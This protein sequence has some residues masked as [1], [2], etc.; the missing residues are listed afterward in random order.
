MNT[1]DKTPD[2]TTPANTVT[3][4]NRTETPETDAAIAAIREFRFDNDDFSRTSSDRVT[5]YVPIP[6][7]EL[8]PLKTDKWPHNKEER[9]NPLTIRKAQKLLAA[10]YAI[11]PCELDEAG[12]YGYAWIIETEKQWVNRKGTAPIIPPGKPRLVKLSQGAQPRMEYEEA[13][14]EYRVYNHLAQEGKAKLNAWFGADMF[15]DLF[16]DGV[17]PVETTPLQMIEHLRVTYATGA[18]DRQ[19][20]ERVEK[21]FDCIY[22]PKKPVETYFQRVR[23]AMTDAL[24]LEQPYTEQQAKNKTLG[25][26]ERCYGE[27]FTKAEA[28]WLEETNNDWTAFTTFWKKQILTWS[29]LKQ[30]AYANEAVTDTDG[31]SHEAR[32][33]QIDMQAL[34]AENRNYHNENQSLRAQQAQLQFALQAEA[35]R[36]QQSNDDI[37]TITDALSTFERRMDLKYANSALNSTHTSNTNSTGLDTTSTDGTRLQ[38]ARER[39]PKACKHLNGGRGKQ[40]MFYCAHPDCGVNCTHNTDRCYGLTKAQKQQFKDAT[41]HDRKGGS[42]KHLERFG[43]YQ[44][45]YDFDSL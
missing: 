41:V 10:G 15:S 33:M 31:L 24:L 25:Q 1:E 17:L 27:S 42:T 43:R 14:E 38:V 23:T 20:M 13:R 2:T 40:Y 8:P 29:R 32:S 39:D 36:Q 12:I 35:R 45:D 9:P 44:R 16:E 21:A 37:S 18:D 19:Y 7:R 34:Q 3:P 6:E 26:F 4:T 22:D 30:K 5:M 28:K 11:I